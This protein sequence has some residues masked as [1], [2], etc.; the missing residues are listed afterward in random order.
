MD[1][2]RILFRYD[3]D[4]YPIDEEEN[5]WAD[6]DG[7]ETYDSYDTEEMGEFEEWE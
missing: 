4:G 5:E 7:E 3:E 2:E 1:E 6:G